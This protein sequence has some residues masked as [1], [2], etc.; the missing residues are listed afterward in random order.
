VSSLCAAGLLVTGLVG[1]GLDDVALADHFDYEMWTDPIGSGDGSVHNDRAED[2]TQ[3]CDQDYNDDRYVSLW[4]GTRTRTRA[5]TYAHN[6]CWQLFGEDWGGRWDLPEGRDWR[7]K[8]C[9]R[10]TLDDSI[11]EGSCDTAWWPA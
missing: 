1:F 2:Q 10:R 4:V 7:F 3:I 11:V 5:S 8:I 9:T 6:R